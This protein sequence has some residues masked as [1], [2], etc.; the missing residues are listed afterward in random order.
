MVAA[1]EGTAAGG[2]LIGLIGTRAN[3]NSNANVQ[4]TVSGG[5]SLNAGG[6]VVVTSD[7]VTLPDAWGMVRQTTR[8][9]PVQP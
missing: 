9:A 3:A 5:A 7:E 2:G 8:R 6:D 4:T 1:D